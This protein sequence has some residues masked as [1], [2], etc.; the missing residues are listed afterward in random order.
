[1]LKITRTCLIMDFDWAAL[2]LQP[3]WLSKIDQLAL[4]RFTQ[5]GLAEEASA[6]VLDKLSADNWARCQSY[7]GKAKPETFV[8]TVINHLLEEFSRSRFGRPR[9]PEWLKR[10]GELWVR[11]WKMLCLERQPMPS[12]A[13]Q[14]SHAA[15]RAAEFVHS[16]MRTIKGRIPSCGQ[17]HREIA[18]DEEVPESVYGTEHTFESALDQHQLED[19]LLLVHELLLG[20]FC[21]SKNTMQHTNT[22]EQ[23]QQLRSQLALS[24]EEC[25]LLKMVYQQ[26]LKLKLVA[27]ALDMPDY[28]PGRLLKQLHQRIADCFRE[29]GIT[30]ELLREPH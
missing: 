19:T 18:A 9:P 11:I 22:P 29:S 24:D 8:I 16:I 26:G 25:L 1:M 7:T 23:W 12:I 17:S 28:Q 4:R 3:N 5:Q 10:E 15:E 30:L 14:L 13:D 27:R 21:P 6:Y 2:V 20:D